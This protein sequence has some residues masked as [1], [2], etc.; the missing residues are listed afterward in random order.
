M[1]LIG[2][3]ADFTE[4]P[5]GALEGIGWRFAWFYADG[6]VTSAECV[7]ESHTTKLLSY[8]EIPLIPS[9]KEYLPWLPVVMPQK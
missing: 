3:V 5:I 6:A 4:S 1:A 8:C 7:V 2:S 9:F